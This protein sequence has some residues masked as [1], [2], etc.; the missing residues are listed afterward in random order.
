MGLPMKPYKTFIFESYEYLPKK[1]VIELRYSLDGEVNFLETLTLPGEFSPA[2]GVNEAELDRALSMLHLIGG[3]SY[4]KTCL[5]EAIDVKTEELSQ[6]H[7][8]FWTT[9]YTHGLGE[10][11]FRNDIDFRNRI[12]FPGTPGSALSPLV[13]QQK[14]SGR[15]L[16]PIGGGK[17][18]MVTIELLKNAG[19]DVTLFR[20]GAHPIVNELARLTGL[21]MI[22]VKRSLSPALF[23]LNEEGALNGHVPITAYVS[24]LTVVLSLIYGFD[25]VAM[26]NER[27]ANIG[28]VDFHGMDINHQWSKGLAFERLFRDYLK[29]YVTADVNYV[30]LLRPFSELRITQLFTEFPQYHGVATSCNTNWKI[31]RKPS[32]IKWCGHCPKCAFVFAMMAAYLPLDRVTKI[33]GKNLFDDVALLPL[34]RSLWGIE[35]WKPF[36]CVG[37]PEETNAAFFLAHERGDADKTIVMKAFLHDVVP[38]IKDPKALIADA[39]KPSDEHELSDPLLR[40]LPA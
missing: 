23:R 24:A 1:G 22:S 5:P 9:V 10:F 35:G 4:Y 34:Y 32:D 7:A 18:S 17:D 8:D 19:L 38:T 27:S 33:F 20:L 39:L 28:N 15:V 37:T 13:P 11:F 25:T 21:P 26:S 29:K 6:E 30:S 31:A 16:V 40:I 2:Q 36:E 3:I 14:P 12:R